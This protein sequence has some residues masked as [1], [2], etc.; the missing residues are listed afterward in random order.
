MSQLFLHAP[1]IR[2]TAVCPVTCAMYHACCVR[3]RGRSVVVH[4]NL[5]CSRCPVAFTPQRVAARA[6]MALSKLSGDEQGI[7]FVQLCNVL[8][9]GIAVAFGSTNSELRA[10]TQALLQ[11]LRTDHEVV[12]T[13]C[14][15]KG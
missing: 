10:L 5:S 12:T 3:V 11:Q 15:N 2:L 6:A 7:V 14:R 1:Y 13:L 4:R 8:N 9:P